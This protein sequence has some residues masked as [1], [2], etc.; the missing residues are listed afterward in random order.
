VQEKKMVDL[1]GK[2]VEGLKLLWLVWVLTILLGKGSR[3]RS[4]KQTN[5]HR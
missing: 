3:S 4:N 2:K 1:E 5:L